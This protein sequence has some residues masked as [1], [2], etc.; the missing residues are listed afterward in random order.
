MCPFLGLMFSESSSFGQD[1]V[2]A[3]P[4]CLAELE[5]KWHPL[6]LGFACFSDPCAHLHL[7]P[8]LVLPIRASGSS[9]TKPSGHNVAFAEGPQGGGRWQSPKLL[10]W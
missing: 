10:I 8:L 5:V 6:P 3:W 2:V 9:S 4:G 1:G 7:P